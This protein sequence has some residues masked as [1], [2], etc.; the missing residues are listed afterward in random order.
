LEELAQAKQR[1]ADFDKEIEEQARDRLDDEVTNLNLRLADAPKEP[2]AVL[3]RQLSEK[4][5]LRTQR[6][7]E[8]QKLSSL[9]ITWLRARLPEDSVARLGAIIDR[10]VL[11][12]VIDEQISINDEAGLIRR[13]K[14][15][16]ENCDPRGY[17][18]DAVSIEFAADAVTGARQLGKM[19]GL[20]MT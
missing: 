6:E 2:L 10:R 20:R 9:F 17:A 11:E 16:A 13:L 1:F 8:V 7:D 15:A 18:D 4:Q 19:D 12:S 3:E 5:V 14:A